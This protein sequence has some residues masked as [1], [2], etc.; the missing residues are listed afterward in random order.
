[1]NIIV[2][3]NFKSFKGRNEPKTGQVVKVY[4][5]LHNGLW[6]IKDKETGLVLGHTS[7]V[8]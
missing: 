1:M 4:K 6:S 5:N 7:E 8:I 3:N 2:E